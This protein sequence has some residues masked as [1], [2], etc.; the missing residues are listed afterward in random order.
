MAATCSNGLSSYFS[1]QHGCANGCQNIGDTERI[2]SIGTGALLLLSGLARGI[3]GPGR[4]LLL[5]AA[6]GGLIYR[7]I[8]GHCSL[9]E[10]M[11][12]STN[13]EPHKRTAFLF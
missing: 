13:H 9:Y 1:T 11:E 5:M 8:T 12:V 3:R 6:G 7:G 4:G 2:V 10:A